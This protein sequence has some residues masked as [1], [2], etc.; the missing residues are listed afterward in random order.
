MSAEDHEITSSPA[1]PAS[2]LHLEAMLPTTA[3][4]SNGFKT[5]SLYQHT[6]YKAKLYWFNLTTLLASCYRSQFLAATSH[7]HV[8]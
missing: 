5:T 1:D 8:L 3:H 4:G 6:V 7:S 2:G